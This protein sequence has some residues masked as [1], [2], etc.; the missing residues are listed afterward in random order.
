MSTA[1]AV[2]G[3]SGFVGQALVA[4]LLASGRPVRAL[5]H[6][7]SLAISHPDLEPV[8]G[9][10]S[11]TVALGRLMEGAGAIIHVA[12]R[13]RGRDDADFMPVNA[14]GV[15]RVAQAARETP[16]V[17]RFVLISSLAA[18]EPDLSPYAASKRAGEARL[19]DVAEGS[20]LRCAVLRPP[21]IYGPGDTELLPLLQLMA[22]GVVPMPGAAGARASLLH[23]DDLAKAAVKLLDS[24]A[25]GTYE[26][27]DGHDAGY[28]WE[29]IATIVEGAAGRGRGWRLKL[30]EG[31]L[32]SVAAMNLLAA[33]LFG[34]LPMMTP[35]KINELRHPD[36]VCDNTEITLATGWQPH[37]SL[38]DGLSPLLPGRAVRPM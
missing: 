30:P 33:R 36:W 20:D 2:T 27:H 7:Q 32:R 8:T 31:V 35:G 34:Y 13:V 5:V 17:T 21:A 24:P 10:L 15:A 16:S 4:H 29:E 9:G 18:R 11:D 26:L 6:R 22:R 28:S 1:V 25:Q 14:E 38:Q 23:V 19:A 3:A 37:I 12:G